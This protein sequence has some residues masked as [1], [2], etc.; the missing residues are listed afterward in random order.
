MATLFVLQGPDKGRTFR[1]PLESVLIGRESDVVPITDNTVSRR[2]ARLWPENGTWLIEDLSS[3][4]GT[5]V[6]GVRA[7]RPVKL[8]R[9]DQIKIGT[10]VL[11]YCG[12]ER[13]EQL[14]GS[15]I[16]RGMIDLDVSGRMLDS[17]ILSSI[18]SNEDS[19]VI[20]APETAEA[21]HA[22]RVMSQLT[23]AIGAILSPDQLLERVMDIIFEQVAVDRGFIL[24]YDEL[25]RDFVPQVVRYRQAEGAG[26]TITT[27]RTIIH[28]VVSRREGVLCTN[29]M[30]DE[31]FGRKE[32]ADSIHDYRLRSVICVP[33][34]AHDQVLGVIHIDC[35]MSNHTYTPE[36]L[37][38]VTAIGAMTGMAIQNARLV[39]SRMET[40]RLAATGETV[41]YLSHAIRNILQG[42]RGGADVVERG[43]RREDLGTVARGWEVVRRNLDRVYS[44]T[45]NMLA[46]SKDRRP[47]LEV[48]Q[49]NRIA[50]EAVSMVQHLADARGIVVMPD[51]DDKMPPLA[52][53]AEGLRQVL[54]NLLNNALDVVPDQTGVI[55]LRTEFDAE[56]EAA[57]IEVADNGPGI[58]RDHLEL[59][60]KP[61]HST[62]GSRGTGLGLAVARKV[63]Q[64]HGGQI[65]VSSQLGHGTTFTIYLPAAGTRYLDSS[66]T[67]GP[68]HL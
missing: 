28:H 56:R 54:L 8:K 60:F 53:D 34:I 40:E 3:A 19:V 63:V 59:I 61:F 29:A 46:F 44:M 62:K 6:N 27:S 43:L 20:A 55:N 11:V 22:W 38:L 64:E 10:T 48:V 67:Q 49:I 16:P 14:T 23:E 32:S 2:H 1:T 36:Q 24:L 31:R 57:R 58:P 25:A 30:T 4:N 12:D 7:H 9:G 66:E 21:V 5:Y 13:T 39:Q 33:I 41:A 45:V 17:S 52:V 42:L 50:E 18:P 35:S 26:K 65:T 51:L 15:Q 68:I 47:K 37:R